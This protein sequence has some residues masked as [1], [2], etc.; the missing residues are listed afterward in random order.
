M[1]DPTPASG[2]GTNGTLQTSVAA[3][4]YADARRTNAFNQLNAVRLGA[5]AGLLAQSTLQAGA[6]AFSWER[7]AEQTLA[8]YRDVVR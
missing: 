3:A 7:T 6:Q 8:V 5:G 1:P 4:S 2:V